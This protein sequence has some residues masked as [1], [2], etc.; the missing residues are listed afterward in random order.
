LAY[1]GLDGN[2]YLTDGTS[3]KGQA[4]TGSA[5]GGP[6]DK[7]P[8]NERSLSFRGLTWSSDGSILAF[9]EALKDNTVTIV[10]S[11]KVPIA[12]TKNADSRFPPAF[13]PD[14]KEV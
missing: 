3:A 10:Q 2:V 7:P 13:S 6:V 9:I 12:V 11:G 1:I 8:F 4:V 5:T 14:N